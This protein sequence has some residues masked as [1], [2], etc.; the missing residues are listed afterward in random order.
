MRVKTLF[1]IALA[2][3]GCRTSDA[4]T[5]L[6]G[7]PSLHSMTAVSGQMAPAP[8][9]P[10]DVTAALHDLAASLDGDV[11]IAVMDVQDGWISD[12]QGE[13]SFP[14][15]SVAKLWVALNVLDRVDRGL[16]RLDTPIMVRPQD[17]S[18]FSQPIAAEVRPNGLLVTNVGNL[19]HRALVQSDNAADDM[20]IRISG[21]V[22]AVE[23]TIA[24]RGLGRI[25]VGDEQMYLQSRIAGLTWQ[26]RFAGQAPEFNAARAQVPPEVR[27]ARI[28]EYVAAPPDGATPN[29][30]VR[31]LAQL[32]RGRLL[33]PQSTSVMLAEMHAARTGRMRLAGGLEP[34]WSIAHKTGTG[35]D[36]R[37]E[38]VGIN[39]VGILTAPDGR[40]YA[41]AVYIARTGAPNQDRLAMMREVTRTVIE[42]WRRS[43]PGYVPPEDGEDALTVAS[44]DRTASAD[45]RAADASE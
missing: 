3:A 10:A 28:S 39:D 32:A 40:Q 44:L 43:Q 17:L 24:R 20:L 14:Q 2:L 33:S 11:G 22:P 15:Q 16:L 4:P 6:T 23:E 26:P 25:A 9:G 31:A 34:G 42:H 29:A 19:L 13:R 1:V 36:F 18:V 38:S 7:G 30:T 12:V 37:G 5:A 35:P 41:V 45:D 27:L 21:G 8:P